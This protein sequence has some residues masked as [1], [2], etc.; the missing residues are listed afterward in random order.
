MSVSPMRDSSSCSRW[1]GV[2]VS[3]M[4]HPSAQRA[5]HTAAGVNEAGCTAMQA[6]THPPATP[7]C[8]GWPWCCCGG[9]LQRWSSPC[10]ARCAR[11]LRA[12]ADTEGQVALGT[13]S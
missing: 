4:S 9:R 3:A 10:L 5:R 13:T 12:A 1:I 11:P 7:G 6:H 8:T 2:A